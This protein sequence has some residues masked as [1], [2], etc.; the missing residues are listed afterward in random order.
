MARLD[1]RLQPGASRTGFAGWHGDVARLAVTAPAVDGAANRAAIAALA[2]LFGVRRRQVE[3]VTGMTS[4]SKRFEIDEI[5]QKR[6]D[7]RL[8]ELN[9]RGT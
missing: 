6:C 5:T 7:Q 8:L 1:V 9:P 2:D 4:R 3:L